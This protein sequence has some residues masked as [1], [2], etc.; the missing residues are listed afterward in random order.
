MTGRVELANWD[1]E[2]S[3]AVHQA[4]WWQADR[5]Q[6]ARATLR[7][8]PGL[9]AGYGPN[10]VAAGNQARQYI[11]T[12]RGQELTAE[13]QFAGAVTVGKETVVADALKTGRQSVLQ[14]AAD[15]LLGCD[16]D[17]LVFSAVAVVL[18]GVGDLAVV[19]GQQ[20]AVG[21]GHAVSVAAEIFEDML[22]TTKGWFGVDHP[23]L[24][25]QR[26]EIAVE[27]CGVEQSLEIA[28]ELEFSACVGIFQCVQK[29]MPEAAAEHLDGQEEF[30]IAVDPA[31]LIGR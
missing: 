28:E 14:E 10:E 25:A 7:A 26:G 6:N 22:G 12:P 1:V 15:E 18:P 16:R 24:F 3:G 2:A 9:V 23:F 11:G 29:Q 17:D 20:A 27:S 5:H 21:D 31:F 19:Q 8:T 4:R 13:F 30:S